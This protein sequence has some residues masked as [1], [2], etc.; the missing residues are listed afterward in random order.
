MK[1]GIG[2]VL[3]EYLKDSISSS[4]R[5]DLCDWLHLRRFCRG[6]EGARIKVKATQRPWRIDGELH[7]RS[8]QKR[9][10]FG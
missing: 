3:C 1:N 9:R 4:R 2:F 7:N 6:G 10:P 8:K 5:V